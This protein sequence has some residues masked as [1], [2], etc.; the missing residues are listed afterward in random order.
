MVESFT[1][2]YFDIIPKW[3]VGVATTSHLY[4]YWKIVICNTSNGKAS[5]KFK[6]AISMV[7]KTFSLILI[8]S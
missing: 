8:W 1:N 3:E 4:R 7:I 2:R 5:S 6:A